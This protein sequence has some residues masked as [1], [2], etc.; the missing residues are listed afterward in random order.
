MGILQER[1]SLKDT[2]QTYFWLDG[3]AANWTS[4]P[5]FQ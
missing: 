2:R 5:S 4:G 1:S 3:D